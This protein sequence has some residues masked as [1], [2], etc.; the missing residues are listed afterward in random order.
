MLREDSVD[1]FSYS[2]SRVI[3]GSDKNRLLFKPV[4]GGMRIVDLSGCF[5]E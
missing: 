3:Y 4:L 1:I 2:G 5:H